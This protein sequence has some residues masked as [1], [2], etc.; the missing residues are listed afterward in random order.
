MVC[1]RSDKNTKLS[2]QLTEILLLG[3]GTT[4]EVGKNKFHNETGKRQKAV[5]FQTNR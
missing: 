2:G 1:P 5:L 4:A 3:Q